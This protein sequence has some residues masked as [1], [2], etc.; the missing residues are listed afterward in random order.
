[1]NLSF[2]PEQE[3]LRASIGKMLQY[4][5]SNTTPELSAQSVYN[6]LM[7]MGVID[8]ANSSRQHATEDDL[9][10]VMAVTEELGRKRVAE[11]FLSTFLG[12]KLLSAAGN[13]SDIPT[14]VAI[15]EPDSRYSHSNPTTTAQKQDNGY[16]FNGTKVAVT[17]GNTARQYLVYAGINGLSEPSTGL[18]VIDGDQAGIE[19]YNYPTIDDGNGCSLKFTNLEL[20][21]DALLCHG[22]PAAQLITEHLQVAALLLSA[23][24]L[25]LMEHILQGS[26]EYCNQREQFKQP[27]GKFQVIQHRLADMYIHCQSIRSLLYAGVAN[28]I[29]RS[30]DAES[31]IAAL[32]FKVGELGRLAAEVAVQVH[33]ATGFTEEYWLGKYYRRLLV[34][35]ALY[36]NTDHHLRNYIQ[37]M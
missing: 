28:H 16:L 9:T 5:T 17:M 8:L 30:A 36:G 27:I 10:S 1:M 31:S 14:G 22:E 18:F 19:I 6:E 32:K 24:A 20:G 15:F 34:I 37:A 2:T 13:S 23:E 35:D 26:V 12:A 4:Q 3:Q 21:D 25:G 33:G 11:P 29:E 7:E